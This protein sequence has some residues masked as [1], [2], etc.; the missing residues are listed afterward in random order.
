[1][2]HMLPL[3]KEQGCPKSSS[4]RV[5]VFQYPRHDTVAAAAPPLD[6]VPP[7]SW[8]GPPASPSPPWLFQGAEVGSAY[9][10]CQTTRLLN[11]GCSL[12]REGGAISWAATLGVRLAL[13]PDW[14]HLLRLNAGWPTIPGSSG[15][16]P[17]SVT[18]G[19]RGVWVS[20]GGVQV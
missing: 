19:N 14:S 16:M 18:C 3:V 5:L 12:G 15:S 10:G 9:E 7:S 4:A 6:C 11:T 13:P 17:R 20:S 8:P 2:P 1:M